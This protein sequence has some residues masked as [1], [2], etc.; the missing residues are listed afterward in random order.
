LRK[1]VSTLAFRVQLISVR[2]TR[3][4]NPVQVQDYEEDKDK[5]KDEDEVFA[6]RN[7]PGHN[8]G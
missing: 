4:R 6:L 3:I 7:T 1:G 5:D 8:K 2:G